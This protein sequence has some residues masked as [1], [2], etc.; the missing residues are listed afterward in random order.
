ML[1]NMLLFRPIR[2]LTHE[3]CNSVAWTALVTVRTAALIA[4]CIQASFCYAY[5]SDD[6]QMAKRIEAVVATTLTSKRP[7]AEE[8][9]LAHEIAGFASSQFQAS[10]ISLNETDS[11]YLL[12]TIASHLSSDPCISQYPKDSEVRKLCLRLTHDDILLIYKCWNSMKLPADNLHKDLAKETTKNADLIIELLNNATPKGYSSTI[13]DLIHSQYS[14]LRNSFI[15]NGTTVFFKTPLT[16]DERM[17]LAASLSATIDE[18]K[19]Q[20]AKRLAN[21][22]E[23][24]AALIVETWLVTTLPRLWACELHYESERNRVAINGLKDLIERSPDI[25]AINADMTEIRNT[26]VQYDRDRLPEYLAKTE[27]EY[28]AFS[29]KMNAD[30]EKRGKD[31]QAK[32][33]A[34]RQEYVELNNKVRKSTEEQVAQLNSQAGSAK[35]MSA[36]QVSSANP[37]TPNQDGDGKLDS[38][39]LWAALASLIICAIS[40]TW[41]AKHRRSGTAS[42]TNC[43]ALILLIA[44]GLLCDAGRVGG[45]VTL[46]A[47]LTG[48][49]RYAAF[50]LNAI[51]E[52]SRL[53][54]GFEKKW[55][56]ISESCYSRFGIYPVSTMPQ[57]VTTDII[58][59]VDMRMQLAS[60]VD[61]TDKIRM[62]INDNSEKYELN[63]LA[64]V[65]CE[66]V[67]QDF[68]LAKD[69]SFTRASSQLGQLLVNAE[70]MHEAYLDD[71]AF[72]GGVF[73]EG[74]AQVQ[75]CDEFLKAMRIAMQNW[76]L[77]EDEVNRDIYTHDNE[78]LSHYLSDIAWECA[79]YASCRLSD[80]ANRI[81]TLC[82]QAS[83]D[84]SRT[85]ENNLSSTTNESSAAQQ[86]LYDDINASECTD[87]ISLS[88]IQLYSSLHTN[89]KT[90]K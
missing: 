41:Y 49:L 1:D 2:M 39:C 36:P 87:A 79:V 70:E 89:S 20:L 38:I 3:L 80:N 19:P 23:K 75:F 26:L 73:A 90:Q 82:D 11:E 52:A 18:Q 88:L 25:A 29:D 10:K 62:Y 30:A 12:T 4:A 81:V 34:A 17:A 66:V 40:A 33:R 84:S 60:A 42:K 78:A 6:G 32:Q 63:V 59:S 83:N 58:F 43:V 16:N 7:I 71:P 67:K 35:N 13:R 51:L 48:P 55:P 76:S 14:S 5:T 9:D 46:H 24:Q 27:A 28:V 56:K 65:I 57:A 53:L 86:N 50:R 54:P 85:A 72:V 47:P 68:G 21:H 45:G 44:T 8:D 61:F 64:C 74:K 31:S 15:D 69:S 22:S 37:T 77:V